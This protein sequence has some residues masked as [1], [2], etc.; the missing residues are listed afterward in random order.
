[1]VGEAIV[2][3]ISL[4]NSIYNAL[5]EI[6]DMNDAVARNAAVIDLLDKLMTAKS[7]YLF[8]Q[9]RVGELE[10]EI[11]RFGKHGSETSSATNL[12]KSEVE[13]EPKCSRKT[14]TLLR[15]PMRYVQIAI[16]TDAFPFFR[17]R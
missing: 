2:G 15:R 16:T 5:K 8:I 7:D 10:Q 1:M 11:K 6:K 3:G 17:K 13:G 12:R 9:E 14:W 4:F